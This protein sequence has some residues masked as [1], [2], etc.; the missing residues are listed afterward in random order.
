MRARLGLILLVITLGT[1]CSA[2]K[3]PSLQAMADAA[4]RCE[5]DDEGRRDRCW[6][7]FE[8]RKW[9]LK[10]EESATDMAPVALGMGCSTAANTPKDCYVIRSLLIEGQPGLCSDEEVAAVKRAWDRA[11]QP[12][13][14]VDAAMAAAKQALE[15]IKAR[16]ARAR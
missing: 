12:K 11:Y 6:S 13:S 5:A 15:G 8:S 9:K 2:K 3:P 4:C 10:V 1:A 16:R 14:D 7:A